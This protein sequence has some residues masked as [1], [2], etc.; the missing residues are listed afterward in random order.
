MNRAALAA[1]ATAARAF[2]DALDAL[3]AAGERGDA[4]TKSDEPSMISDVDRA[5]ARRVLRRIER[6]P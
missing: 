6:G 4:G 5:R 2:A 3:R 1:A